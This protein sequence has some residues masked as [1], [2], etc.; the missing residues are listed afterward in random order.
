MCADV[1]AVYLSPL[2]PICGERVLSRSAQVFVASLCRI[3]ELD[4][5][6]ELVFLPDFPAPPFLFSARAL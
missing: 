1:N 5:G 2:F 4:A 3:D 6:S